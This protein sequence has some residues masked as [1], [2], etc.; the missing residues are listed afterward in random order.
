MTGQRRRTVRPASLPATVWTGSTRRP[1]G[2]SNGV[3]SSPASSRAS[4]TSTVTSCS[5]ASSQGTSSEPSTGSASTSL[6]VPAST[7]TASTV[8]DCTC[9]KRTS[10]RTVVVSSGSSRHSVWVDQGSSG[11]LSLHS[12]GIRTPNCQRTWFLAADAR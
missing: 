12:R 9:R 7:S 11:P 2:R 1:P 6:K 3:V 10:T 5:V 8:L 4:G